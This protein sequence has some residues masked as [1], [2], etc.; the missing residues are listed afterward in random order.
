[1][2]GGAHSKI[3]FENPKSLLSVFLNL[4]MKPMDA[5]V[6]FSLFSQTH[7]DTLSPPFVFPSIEKSTDS[8]SVPELNHQS[9]PG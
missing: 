7:T 8:P 4:A 9:A 1:M 6:C 2:R 3:G 5:L